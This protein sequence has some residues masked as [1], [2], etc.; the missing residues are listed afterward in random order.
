MNYVLCFYLYN[1]DLQKV[2]V[3]IKWPFKLFL[4]GG[5]GVG[6]T[7]FCVKFIIFFLNCSVPPRH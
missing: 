3:E 4:G 5:L 6:K 1:M 2:D 7:T